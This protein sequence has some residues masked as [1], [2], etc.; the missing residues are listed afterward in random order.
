MIRICIANQ[1]GGVGK[2]TTAINLGAG[3]SLQGRKVLIID[4]DPQAN[5][6]TG[7][8][9]GFSSPSIYEVLLGE[10]KV[11]EVIKKTKLENLYLLPSHPDLVGIEVELRQMKNWQNRLKEIIDKMEGKWDY[12]IIDTPPSLNIFT[13]KAMI[14]S[15]WI[16]VPVQCEYYALEGLGQL[17]NTVKFVKKNLNPRLKIGGFLFTMYDSKTKLS[18]QV[19]EEVKKYL[20]DKVFKSVIPRNVRVAEAPSFGEPVLTF[21]P[22][23]KGALAYKKF[24]EE[25][26]NEKERTWKGTAS[27]F[28]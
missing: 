19:V 23:S 4:F 18:H 14:A 1:K 16:I 3:L 11:F 12:V 26:I 21:A 13:T 6:T 10:V 8:G 5:A 28:A 24:V 27:S 22:H 2:T 7:L 20:G 9:F 25:V 15:E 17:L